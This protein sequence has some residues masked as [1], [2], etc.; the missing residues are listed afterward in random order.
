MWSKA[1]PAYRNGKDRVASRA[2]ALLFIPPVLAGLVQMDSQRGNAEGKEMEVGGKA[3]NT[4]DNYEAKQRRRKQQENRAGANVNTRR[5]RSHFSEQKGHSLGFQSC[6]SCSPSL[7]SSC[8]S[9]LLLLCSPAL[10]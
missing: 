10:L 9:L 7:P 3:S 8:L 1:H 2:T 4:K 6:P 5:K